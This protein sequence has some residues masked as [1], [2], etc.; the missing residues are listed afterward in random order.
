MKVCAK[1]RQ[2]LSIEREVPRSSTCPQCGAYLHSCINCKFYSPGSHNDCRE[3]QADY[4]SDK[5]SSN[6]C[7]Y[8][9]FIETKNLKDPEEQEFRKKAREKFNNLF[10]DKE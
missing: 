3:P 7:D 5:R 9:L 4:V 2:I 6:F 1:C 8:F 10:G